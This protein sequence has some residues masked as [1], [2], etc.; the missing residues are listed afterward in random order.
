[1][2]DHEGFLVRWSRLKR[3]DTA[4]AKPPTE[5][6]TGPEPEECEGGDGERAELPPLPPL[7]S[8]GADSDYTR[9]LAPDVP[10]E[11]RRLA[12]RRAWTT[13]PR[14]AGFRGF[15]EYDWDFNAPGYGRLLACDDIGRLLGAVCLGPSDDVPVEKAETR[16]AKGPDGGEE[17]GAG[18]T[19]AS[20]RG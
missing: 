17:D 9:F 3:E 8:L 4:Q 12:M 20:D 14:I 6:P 11:L 13:D 1:M 5:P 10:E 15:G 2:A 18:E 7:E 16:V 19:D